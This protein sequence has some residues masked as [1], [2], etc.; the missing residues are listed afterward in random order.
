MV[1]TVSGSRARW[2]VLDQAASSLTNFGLTFIVLRSTSLD[3]FGA[4]TIAFIAYQ[5]A[6][7][8][9][10]ALVTEPLV[11]RFSA[12]ETAESRKAIA[13]AAGALVALG[14]VAGVFLCAAATFF[15]SPTRPAMLI[16]GISLPFLLLQ[17][18]VRFAFFA[19]GFPRRAFWNDVTWGFFTALLL[20]ATLL[21]GNDSLPPLMVSWVTAGAIASGVGI[22]RLQTR[23]RFSTIGDWFRQHGDLGRRYVVEYVF[24][25]GA[26][27]AS[28][29]AV[30]GIA[31]LAALGAINGTRVL[32]GPINVLH[33]GMMA[34]A[35]P[36]GVRL[37][38][39]SPERLGKAVRN[40]AL[41]LVTPALLLGILLVLMPTAVGEVLVQDSDWSKIQELIAP[42][43]LFV[44]AQGFAQSRRAGLRIVADARQSMWA[45]LYSSPLAFL[46][47]VV[48]ALVAG[49][50]GAAWGFAIAG[51]ASAFI[52]A[53]MYATSKNVPKSAPGNAR[54]LK[55]TS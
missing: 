14:T 10:R 51:L 55:D 30:G 6:L 12:S 20:G 21:T 11:I 40:L 39:G 52:W 9:G 16:I 46:G 47:S 35:V 45:Q 13:A 2:S 19:L 33:S 23:P 48:G 31:G 3:H 1:A 22:H 42:T 53:I 38:K 18:G 36:E 37:I 5:M 25:F 54:T 24:A 7:N 15:R 8:L 28:L 49:G 32:F 50:P 44:A 34:F 43:A 26:G 27:Y 4:F 17:D 41:F 29:F